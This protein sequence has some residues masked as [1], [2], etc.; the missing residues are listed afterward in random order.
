[1]KK[2]ISDIKGFL[3]DLDGTIYRGNKL[4]PGAV[5][6]I[7]ML[8]RGDKKFLIIS[9]NSSKSRRDYK[10]KLNKFGIEIDEDQIFTST[11]ATIDYIK[12]KYPKSK[13]YPVGTPEFEYELRSN[14]VKVSKNEGD[15][16]L[17]GFDKTLT[18][19]KIEVAVRLI[20]NG[21]EFIATHSDIL[22]PVEKGFI[23]DIGTMIALFEKATNRLPKVIGKPNKEM[24]ESAL[25]KLALPPNQV[26]MVGD[27]L[28]TDMKMAHDFGIT[29]IL[30][31][32]GE[33]KE[34][35]LLDIPSKPDYI[36]KSVNDILEVLI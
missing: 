22:C 12:K 15:V 9:N 28:Y 18:Y 10:N 35:D 16:V 14:D 25:L 34:E 6:F 24:V 20:N 31:L 3:I 7:N 21:A 32:S 5:E 1:M 27:R 13:I 19:N 26:A 11:I 36:F 30:V 23:P 17:L 8:K 29:S 2:K 33:T 4:V